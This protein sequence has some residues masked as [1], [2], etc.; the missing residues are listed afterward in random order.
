MTTTFDV[1]KRELARSIDRLSPEQQFNVV[2]MQ[3]LQPRVF[4][5]LPVAATAEQKAAATKFLESIR[6]TGTSDPILGLKPAF[7]GH[8]Q[9]LFLVTDLD[10]EDDNA[11]VADTIRQL[12]AQRRTV[13]NTILFVSGVVDAE[14]SPSA[15]EF[16]AK[17][18]RENG[19]VF[20]EIRAVN[21]P[22]TTGADD[23]AWG[24][25]Q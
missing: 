19:G 16:M 10:F 20:R 22:T 7:A 14:S 15:M 4:H 24:T 9:V 5:A 12:N 18:A 23:G 3:D 11:A 2:V 13:V 25:E 21:V 17:L 8:P 1:L 6:L